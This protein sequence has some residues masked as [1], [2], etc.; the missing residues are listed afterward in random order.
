M[1]D[2]YINGR[3]LTQ[4]I[5]GVQRYANEIVCAFDALLQEGKINPSKNNIIVLIPYNTLKLPDYKYVQI[6]KIG[7]FSGNLWEQTSLACFAHNKKLLNL[8]NSGP[9]LGGTNQSLT[10]HDTSI[11]AMPKSY[12]KMFRL[13]SRI[14]FEFLGK[15]SKRIYTVSNFSKQEIR[16]YCE[17]QSSKIFVV[18]GSGD[19]MLKIGRDDT[20][21]EKLSIIN[22]PYLLA[23]SSNSLHK[24][25]RNLSIALEQLSEINFDVVIVGGT[26]NKIF[27]SQ[28]CS[29]PPFVKVIGYVSDEELKS[30]YEKATAFI[31]PSIYEGFGLPPLEAMFCGTRVLLSFS[32]SLP[33]VG[34]NAAVYFDPQSVNDI[35]EKI[36]N[37]FINGDNFNNIY[38]ENFNQIQKFSW[39]RSA[40]LIWEYENSELVLDDTHAK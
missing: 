4:P 5:T 19:H 28:E 14:I 29:Y 40:M 3:F 11:Y 39:K 36:R 16:K 6:K 20:I 18:P 12:S 27:S 2:L 37:V 31:Y 38:T 34:G 13:K 8:C 33:E 26:N 15:I 23:V 1:T 25:F 17:I 22:K 21:L 7:R 10:I 30:L 9:F 32:T 35:S 24:N